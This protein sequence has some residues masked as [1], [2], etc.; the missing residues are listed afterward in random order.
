TYNLK[1]P[2]ERATGL[3]V[4]F[5]NAANACALAEVWFGKTEGIRDLAAVTVSEGIGVGFFSN[6]HL[7]RG[8]DGMAGEFGHVQLDPCGPACTCG[9]RGCWE[10]FAS[11]RAVV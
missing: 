7:V 1:S 9:G 3:D 11:N 4:E 2:I 8:G 6:G 10:V 5:E